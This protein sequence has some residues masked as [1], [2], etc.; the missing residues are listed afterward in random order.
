[1]PKS[2]ANRD[3]K[4][5]YQQRKEKEQE[6]E[7]DKLGYTPTLQDF[8]RVINQRYGPD[9][10]S[11]SQIIEYNFCRNYLM[12]DGCRSTDRAATIFTYTNKFGIIFSDL[13]PAEYNSQELYSKVHRSMNIFTNIIP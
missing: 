13:Q 7:L 9:D 3:Y 6:R 1:M 5:E 4:K 8:E 12:I 2:K 10:G 11:R